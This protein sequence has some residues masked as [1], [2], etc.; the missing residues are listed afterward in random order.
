MKKG[1]V[2]QGIVKWFSPEKGYGF[3]TSEDGEDHYFNVQ[4][5]N[6]SAL[7]SNGDSVS[8]E[9][10]TGDRGL[11]AF[12]VTITGRATTKNNRQT[13]DRISCSNCQ[14]KITPRIITY[15]GE[16][17]KSVCPYCAATVN[18]FRECP[19]CKK[20]IISK[21]PQEETVCPYCSWSIGP[22]KIETTDD[23][24]GCFI[25]TAVYGDSFCNQVVE[26]RRFRDKVLLNMVTGRLFVKYY[27]KVSPF[28]AAWLITKPTLSK[29]IR[30]LLDIL[31]KHITRRS[32]P[33]K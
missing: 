31:V 10:K 12:N 20:T 26:L 21:W 33:V 17:Q 27:Y 13:D 28:I 19:A 16:P 25:A 5:I 30:F 18:E 14:K 7:T 11:R 3:I 29:Q 2:V 9:S 23:S 4:S 8:F 1:D 15:N 24:T 32:S 6:G 22:R